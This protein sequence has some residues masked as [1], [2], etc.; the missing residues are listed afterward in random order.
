M[1][2]ISP[3]SGRGLGGCDAS[4]GGDGLEVVFAEDGDG[5]DGWMMV[6]GWSAARI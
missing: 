1:Y 2:S 6:G 5:D 3:W 4:G